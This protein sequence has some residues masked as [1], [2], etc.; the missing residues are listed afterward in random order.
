MRRKKL[1][2]Q[3][4][5]FISILMTLGATQQVLAQCN[6][7]TK[8][9]LADHTEA[10][11]GLTAA[12]DRL[13]MTWAGSSDGGFNSM[14]SF[15]GVNWGYKVVR[16]DFPRIALGHGGN[17]SSPRPSGGVGM[18]YSP[19]CGCVYAGWRDTSNNLWATRSVDGI[20]WETAR[21]ILRSGSSLAA[22]AITNLPCLDCCPTCDPPPPPPPP[23]PSGVAGTA[24]SAPALRGDDGSLPIGFAVTIPTSSS[25]SFLASKGTF[26]CDFSNIVFPSQADFFDPPG[27]SPYL[28]MPATPG[29]TGALGTTKISVVSPGL[30]WAGM[31]FEWNNSRDSL[32]PHW[33][34]NGLATTV[35]P[36]DGAPYIAWT[37]HD[38]GGDNCSPDSTGKI[39]I[40]NVR[41]G[42]HSGCA[43]WSIYNPAMTFF[44]GKIWIAW[45]GR[46]SG[47]TGYINIASLNPF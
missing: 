15:D 31:V 17:N 6:W 1:E 20:N 18:T 41:T 26:N 2:I 37:C 9:I 10:Q 7:S 40:R 35:N 11:L 38:A 19:A 43:D 14:I 46:E 5:F 44:Q 27:G 24:L 33:S 32:G 34:N 22:G 8:V 42:A 28:Y 39:N 29:Y 23:P 4:G 3:L 25:A 30:F 45:R 21:K 36:D 12:G 47:Q 16:L 13:V